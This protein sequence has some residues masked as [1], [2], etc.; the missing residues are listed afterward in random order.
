MK[1]NREKKFWNRGLSPNKE[2]ILMESE[3]LWI[4]GPNALKTGWLRIKI[5]IQL[6]CICLWKLV[7]KLGLII[8]LSSLPEE[9]C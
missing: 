2:I 1:T 8:D 4:S 7:K 5:N 9:S 3:N 6:L